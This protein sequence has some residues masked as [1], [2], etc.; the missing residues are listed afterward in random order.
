MELKNLQNNYTIIDSLRSYPFFKYIFK[1]YWILFIGLGLLF[2]SK[3]I[4]TALLIL[5]LIL[6]GGFSQMYR[7]FIPSIS[8]GVELIT[9]N[10]LIIS[11]ITNP[12]IGIVA[13]AIMI[14]ISTYTTS[15]VCHWIFIKMVIYALLC[16]TLF[17]TFSFGFKIAGYIFVIALNILY[18]ATNAMFSD[19]RT[20]SDL[21]GNI[22][23]VVLN[24][25]LIGI[26]IN[27]I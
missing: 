20:L 3:S 18:L 25:F 23:N 1:Y 16:L 13:A 17:F 11:F 5:A 7:L 6:I 12:L 21:P 10:T 26:V 8:I 24:F 22:I 9:L 2:F 27:L 19:F 15:R 14:L 4:I